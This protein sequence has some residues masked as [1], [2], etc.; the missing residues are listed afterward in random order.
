MNLPTHTRRSAPLLGMLF[1]TVLTILFLAVTGSRTQGD[2]H[3]WGSIFHQHFGHEHVPP[4]QIETLNGGAWYWM[5]SRSPAQST[6]EPD[7]GRS[8]APQTPVAST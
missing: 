1:A 7:A 5:R 8:T 2:D 6:S 3:P 4:G